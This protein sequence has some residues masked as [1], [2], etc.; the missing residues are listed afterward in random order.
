MKSLHKRPQEQSRSSEDAESAAE[1][2]A[3]AR[4]YL[5]CAPVSTEYPRRSRGVA[6][7][8]RNTR[9]TG[10]GIPAQATNV[11]LIEQPTSHAVELQCVNRVHRVGQ[12]KETTVYRYIASDT[13]EAA[14]ARHH[15]ASRDGAREDAAEMA[16][17]AKALAHHF[18]GRRAATV[19]PEDDA[20]L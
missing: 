4:L 3:Q 1:E 10:R 16:A 2:R 13:I 12:T 7:N 18:A 9:A 19:S 8:P 6:A 15:A 14:I 17:A 5:R 20:D 11:F